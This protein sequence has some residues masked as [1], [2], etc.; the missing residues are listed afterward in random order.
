LRL[1]HPERL[2]WIARSD[3]TRKCQS[4]STPRNLPSW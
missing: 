1:T 2:F 4:A 3:G